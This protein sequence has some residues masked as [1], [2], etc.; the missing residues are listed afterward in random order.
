[1]SQKHD[2]LIEH[3]D[4]PLADSAGAQTSSKTGLHS[5]ARKPSNAGPDSHSNKHQAPVD[6]AFGNPGTRDQGQKD[7]YIEDQ[8]PAEKARK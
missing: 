8:A 3:D 4:A 2:Q 5:S 1:M 6:G 7:T